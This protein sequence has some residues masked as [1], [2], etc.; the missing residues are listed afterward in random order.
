MSLHDPNVE[1][2]LLRIAKGVAGEAGFT[3]PEF[4]LW[5][6]VLRIPFLYLS[7][8]LLLTVFL[9]PAMDRDVAPLIRNSLIVLLMMA[10]IRLGLSH[11]AVSFQRSGFFG[12]LANLPVSGREALNH[13]RI[14]IIR[15]FWFPALAGTLV[16]SALIHD[17]RDA[18]TWPDI[19]VTWS[20]LHAIVWAVLIITQSSWI[21]RLRIV[22]IW[23]WIAYFVIGSFFLLYLFGIGLFLPPADLVKV[24][25]LIDRVI[26]VFPTSWVFPERIYNGGV[27]PTVLL[28]ALGAWSWLR[29]PYTAFPNFDRPQ[30]FVGAFG[31]VGVDEK[32]CIDEPQYGGHDEAEPA[33]TD[34]GPPLALPLGGWVNHLIRMSIPKSDIHAAGAFSPQNK[35]TS[36]VTNMALLFFPLWLLGV[37]F[38][39]KL[40][41]DSEFGDLFHLGIWAFPAVLFL[42]L[43]MPLRNPIPAAFLPYPVGSTPVPFFTILPIPTRALNRI[44]FAIT[45]VRTCIA[46]A[47]ATPFFWILARMYELPE[48]ASGLLAAFP[49]LGVAW[50]FSV[51][52]KISSRLDPHLRRK[53]GI[54]PIVVATSLAVVPI[55]LIWMIG[56]IAGIGASYAW[57]SGMDMDYGFLLLPIAVGCLTFSAVM[58]RIIFE[59]VH[60]S[61]RQQRYDWKSKT[62]PGLKT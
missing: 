33:I 6:R 35:N 24:E 5:K 36:T 62:N 14:L 17:A 4:P 54:L 53:R 49:A 47:I 16:G 55:G 31:N 27:I 46:V 11:I 34:P 26:W 1:R 20:L 58:S 23:H 2:H 8:I 7:F 44:T 25:T 60:L 9:G 38:G 51:P 12:T 61:L 45:A 13:L 43:L 19:L 21:V 39:K 32:G 15:R 3:K 50:I 18:E 41:P 40:I 10:L 42:V 29:W 30:D 37:E 28:L 56:G 48:V 57:A 52:A 59:V 22:S